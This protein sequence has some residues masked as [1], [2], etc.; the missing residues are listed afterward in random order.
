[1][2]YR[3]VAFDIQK[4]LKQTFDDADITLPQIV[5]WIQTVVNNMR[6]LAYSAEQTDMFTSTYSPVSVLIDEN[7]RKYIDLPTQ[8]LN[9]SNNGGVVYVTYNEETC[10]CN[11]PQF[12]QKWF[13]SVNIGSVQNLYGDPFTK[14]SAKNPYY[15]RV[16]D[17]VNGVSVNRLYLLGI[18]CVDVKDLEIAILSTVNPS[19]LC[20]LDDEVPLP[21]EMII[22]LIKEVLSLGRFITMVPNENTNEGEDYARPITAQAPAPQVNNQQQ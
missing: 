4:S 7:G 17:K 9:L 1:M 16:G 2:T 19:T 3:F 5:Y 14:P 22:D 21:D 15:Y 8:I 20:N 10:C 6:A 18:E 12:A 11:G 13:N